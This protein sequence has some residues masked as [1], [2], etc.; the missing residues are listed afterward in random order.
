MLIYS[1]TKLKNSS[2]TDGGFGIYLDY[3]ACCE[4]K[5]KN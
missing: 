3:F 2:Y 4:G 1:A 5:R